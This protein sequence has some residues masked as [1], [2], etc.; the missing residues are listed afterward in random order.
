MAVV[1]RLK[2]MG[3]RRRPFFRISVADEQKPTDGRT[4]DTLGIYD[5]IAPKVESQHTVEVERARLW[6]SRGARATDTVRS[7]FRRHGV[8]EGQ[9]EPTAR[10]REGR[11]RDTATKRHRAERKKQLEERKSA[12]RAARA[13]ASKAAKA[14]APAE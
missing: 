14:S 1:I 5:P 3:R 8:Y 10:K 7:I 13:E 12:R 4:L 11:D 9:P 6:L 2:R